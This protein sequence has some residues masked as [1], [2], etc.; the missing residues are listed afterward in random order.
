M[1]HETNIISSDDNLIDIHCHQQRPSDHVQIVSLDTMEFADSPWPTTP[2]VFAHPHNESAAK[3]LL[4]NHETNRYFSLGIHPWFIEHQDRQM[5][6]QTLS[7]ASLNPKLLAIG[8]CGLD[9]CIATPMNLQI[10][11]FTWQTEFADRIGKPLI[12]HCVKA[13]NELMQIKKNSK[14][15]SAWI[16]HGF[17]ANPVLVAQLIK[18]GCYLSFGA[19]LS[20][21][22]NHAKQAL[23]E[24]PLDRLFLETDTA[25][26]SISE[27]YAAATKILRINVATLQQQIQSNFKRVFLND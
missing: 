14:T 15:G 7:N 22:H 3:M 17:N 16:I 27:I 13:F 25:D 6:F 20:N 5:A 18:H 4:V 1:P 2:E 21:P 26:V 8:E 19:A 23:I 12:I 11:V 24:M 10:E 9:K